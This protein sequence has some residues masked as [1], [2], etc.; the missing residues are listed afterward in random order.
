MGIVIKEK[1]KVIEEQG[2]T[3]T[4][5]ENGGKLSSLKY[6]WRV[7]E[8]KF[9]RRGPFDDVSYFATEAEADEFI[10]KITRK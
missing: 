6:A 4:A 7:A 5:L 1:V 8:E 9:D 10:R 2:Y 3:Y